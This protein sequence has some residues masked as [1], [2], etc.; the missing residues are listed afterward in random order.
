LHEAVRQERIRALS[1]FRDAIGSG[2]FPK[3]VETA[4]MAPDELDAFRKALGSD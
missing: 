2:D 4:G 3:A 1:G